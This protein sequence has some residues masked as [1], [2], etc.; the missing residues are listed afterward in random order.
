MTDECEQRTIT[1]LHNNP[2]QILSPVETATADDTIPTSLAV[3]NYFTI[4]ED[5]LCVPVYT[6]VNED[7]EEEYY[8]DV[9]YFDAADSTIKVTSLNFDGTLLR[10]RLKVT[11]NWNEPLYQLVEVYAENTCIT[12]TL[13]LANYGVYNFA[14][15]SS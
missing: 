14:G 5:V 7:D 9:V 4:T 3:T 1:N 6:L 13:S 11:T 8:G 15:D 12:S 10:L 2:I